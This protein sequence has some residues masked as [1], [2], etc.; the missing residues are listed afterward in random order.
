[1]S[2]WLTL[3]GW[4]KD[5]PARL[6]QQAAGKGAKY[7]RSR[8]PVHLVYSERLASQGAALRRERAIKKLSRTAKLALIKAQTSVLLTSR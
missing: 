7:T 1:M 8:L 6:A 2:W 4:T 5:V 3:H